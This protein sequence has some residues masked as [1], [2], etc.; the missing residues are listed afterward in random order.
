[1]RCLA[2]GKGCRHKAATALRLDGLSRRAVIGGFTAFADVLGIAAFQNAPGQTSQQAGVNES[3][4]CSDGSNRNGRKHAE[5]S[6]SK[7]GQ[8]VQPPPITASNQVEQQPHVWQLQHACAGS[9]GEG[10]TTAVRATTRARRET[11]RQ[12]AVKKQASTLATHNWS[13]SIYCGDENDHRENDNPAEHVEDAG[14]R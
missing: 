12:P 9:Q 4:R 5:V 3:C 1:M 11:A 2:R 7:Y 6:E 10:E 13:A 14:S 8:P